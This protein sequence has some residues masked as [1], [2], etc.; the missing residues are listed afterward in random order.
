MAKASVSFVILFDIRVFTQEIS[1]INVRNVGRPLAG[2]QVLFNTREYTQERNLT[3]V[4]NVTKVSVN[5][6]ALSTIRRSM[7]R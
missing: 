2:T 6:A 5:S 4:K 3:G 7:Q 1:P